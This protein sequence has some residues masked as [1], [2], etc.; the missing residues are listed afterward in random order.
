VRHDGSA[1]LEAD[2][3]QPAPAPD[4]LRHAVKIGRD[5]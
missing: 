5:C 1:R 4:A 3:A 2:K